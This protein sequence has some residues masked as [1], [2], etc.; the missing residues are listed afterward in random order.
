M[1]DVIDLIMDAYRFHLN[2]ELKKRDGI[3]KLVN[4][5]KENKKKWI[6]FF[7][8][9]EDNNTSVEEKEMLLENVLRQKYQIF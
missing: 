9:I 5:T 6:K 8:K 4:T 3:L 2:H 1:K 7:E